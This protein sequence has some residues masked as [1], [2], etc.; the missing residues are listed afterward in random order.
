MQTA[1]T[2]SVN[3][4]VVAKETIAGIFTQTIRTNGVLGLYKGV[5]APLVAVTPLYAL[6]FW[7]YDMGQ[8][9][10][11][12]TKSKTASDLT[13]MDKCI[14]GGLSAIPT[15]ALMVPSERIKV[16]MQTA[17]P[18]QYR[19]MV[20]CASQL[21]RTGGISSLFRGTGLTLMRDIP[22]SVAWFGMYEASKIGMMQ[23]QGLNDTSK[24]SP[25]AVLTAGG[26]AGLACWIVQ[27]PFDTLK[28]RYQSAP[29]GTYP[30]G[31][32]EV[33]QRLIREEGAGA[34][35]NGIRPALLRAFPANAACFFGMEVSRKFLA[36]MD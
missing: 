4:T 33:F 15:A 10:V 19:G 26:L 1:A 31:P 20:D 27:I 22:G 17:A 32:R 9:L 34:L 18:G 14:A 12:Y 16:L 23:L 24:L 28:S 30:K 6:C 3:G 11:C 13:I 7:S 35:F 36:F 8:R 25:T 29:D 2:T 5:S 21:Y